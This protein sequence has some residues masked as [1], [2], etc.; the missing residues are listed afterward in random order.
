MND[1]MRTAG[2]T[3]LRGERVEVRSDQCVYACPG[4]VLQALDDCEKG[5]LCKV[6]TPCLPEPDREPTPSETTKGG[7]V[8]QRIG[9]KSKGDRI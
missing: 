7:V 2:E 5:Y 1:E 4:G 6:G 8:T 3:L 9:Q